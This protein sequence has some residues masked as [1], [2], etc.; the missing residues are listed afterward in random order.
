MYKI[1]NQKIITFTD[2]Y[3]HA[4]FQT[5][6]FCRRIEKK[7]KSLL[8]GSLALYFKVMTFRIQWEG[9]NKIMVLSLNKG[10][11]EHFSCFV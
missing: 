4:A 8:E 2:N 9:L 6:G 5:Q 10:L 11:Q 7:L 1:G 3:T